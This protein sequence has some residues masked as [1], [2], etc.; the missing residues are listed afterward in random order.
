MCVYVPCLLHRLGIP[1]VVVWCFAA[2]KGLS[3]GI[4]GDGSD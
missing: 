3:V 4:C 2:F 1:Y